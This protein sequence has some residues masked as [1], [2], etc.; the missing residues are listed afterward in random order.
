MKV[1]KSPEIKERPTRHGADIIAGTPQEFG[2]YM[3]SETAKWAKVLRGQAA[4]RSRRQRYQLLEGS[5][6]TLQFLL[7]NLE[8][9]HQVEC[10]YSL[11]AGDAPV[12]R[13]TMRR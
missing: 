11:S 8:A 4:G 9:V 1:L 6:P 13:R 10:G 12:C 3:R 7:Q 5:D 2:T